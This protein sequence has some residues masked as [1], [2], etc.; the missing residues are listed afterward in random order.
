VPRVL[1]GPQALLVRL[2][3]QV[4]RDRQA[5]LELRGLP[6]QREQRELLERKVRQGHKDLQ[7]LLEQLDL[8][9]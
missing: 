4:R 6:G 3:R 8:K 7:A 1:Q 2:E 5:L 9:E